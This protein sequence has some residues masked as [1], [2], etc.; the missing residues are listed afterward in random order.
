MNRCVKLADIEVRLAVAKRDQARFHHV[1]PGAAREIHAAVF[2]ADGLRGHDLECFFGLKHA[3]LVDAGGM[4]KGV[5]AHDGLIGLHGHVADFPHQPTRTHDLLR[6]NA[7]GSFEN[8]PADLERHDDL[9]ERGVAGALAQAVDRAFDLPGAMT[10]RGQRIGRRH[11]QIV[12]AMD[13]NDRFVD[14]GHPVEK[15]AYL[16]GKKFGCGIAHGVRNINRGSAPPDR[17]FHHRA[18]IIVLRAAGIHG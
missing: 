16:R 17:Q 3:V 18:E 11:A 9:F 14:I 7:H 13:R 12:V 10:D 2:E 1:T 6:V 8:V 15:H 4:R 5:A